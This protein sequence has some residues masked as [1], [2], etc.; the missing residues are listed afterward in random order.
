MRLLLD[1]HI[2]IR[3]D[4]GKGLSRAETAAIHDADEVFVSAVSVWEVAIKSALGKVVSTR[5]L[6]QAAR[7][8]GFIELPVTFSQADQVSQL[9][10]HHRDPFDRLLIAQAQVEHLVILTRDPLFRKYDVA[11]L[12]PTSRKNP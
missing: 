7:E 11:L 3:W 4:T 10:P 12:Q 9:P 1:T 8:S 5:T 2:V 6:A